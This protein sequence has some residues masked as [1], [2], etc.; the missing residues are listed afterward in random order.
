MVDDRRKVLV[1]LFSQP[2]I[3]NHHHLLKKEEN[4]DLPNK[5]KKLTLL[6]NIILLGQIIRR[7]ENV[8]RLTTFLFLLKTELQGGGNMYTL[9]DFQ[10]LSVCV[11]FLRNLR[12]VH[13]HHFLDPGMFFHFV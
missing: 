3:K 9:L 8:Q 13:F 11:I 12:L 2:V 10:G 5:E 4:K 6:Q 1:I 7:W